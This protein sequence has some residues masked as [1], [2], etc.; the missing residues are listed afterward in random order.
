[1][2]CPCP[3]RLPPPHSGFRTYPNL[4]F[5]LLSLLSL[6]LPGQQHPPQVISLLPL[7]ACPALPPVRPLA[8]TAT[9]QQHQPAQRPSEFPPFTEMQAFPRLRPSWGSLCHFASR[10]SRFAFQL[11]AGRV[12]TRLWERMSRPWGPP[13]GLR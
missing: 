1:M 13:R 9:A 7:S 2:S 5:V 8:L 3:S 10:L 6:G 12:A 4:L 11:G